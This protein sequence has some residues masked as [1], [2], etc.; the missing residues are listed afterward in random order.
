MIPHAGILSTCTTTICKGPWAGGQGSAGQQQSTMASHQM[1]DSH[2]MR[3]HATCR[4]IKHLYHYYLHGH[5]GRR[6]GQSGPAAVNDG[7]SPDIIVQCLKNNRCA[8]R[9]SLVDVCDDMESKYLEVRAYPRACEVAELVP[10]VDAIVG[11]LHCHSSAYTF[12]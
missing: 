4:D 7:I 6:P 3:I 10:P 2:D 5:L 12:S 8:W 11:A 1:I 9:H